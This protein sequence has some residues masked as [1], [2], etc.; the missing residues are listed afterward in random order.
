MNLDTS[1]AVLSICFSVGLPIA[2]FVARHWLL[3]RIS[4][5]VQHDFDVRL[6]KLRSDLR[7][8]EAEISTLRNSVL[9]GSANRQ[10]LL[11]KRRFEAVEKVWAAVN[12]LGQLK[13]LSAT[14]AILNFKAVAKEASD[15]KMQQF[16]T[17]I[18]AGTPDIQNLNFSNVA[19]NERPF[20]PELAWAYFAAYTTILYGSQARYIVLKSG[21]DDADIYLSNDGAK[22]ILKAA[23]PHRNKFIDENEPGAYY[24]LLEEIEGFL[25]FELRKILEGKDAD[26]TAAAQAKEIIDA[27]KHADD[28]RAENAVADVKDL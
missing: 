24:D 11:D 23:L 26:Q 27:V 4:K 12:D 28:K 1:L 15:P 20:L 10:A 16:I 6:E 9:S 13:S 3:A 5:S 2:I 8:K 7:D 17:A 25:L 18:G 14:M 22:K 21:L 19:T